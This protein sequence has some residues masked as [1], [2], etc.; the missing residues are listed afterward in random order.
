MTKLESNIFNC[1]LI[2]EGGGMRAS[3][4][5]AVLN[6][7]LAEGVHFNHVYGVSAG[8]SN[9]VN[10]IS[11]DA[12]RAFESFTTFVEDPEFGNTRTF[13]QRKGAFN[14]QHIYQEAGE[15]DGWLPFDFETFAANPAQCTICAF[16]RDT[17]N[18]R[19]FT[20]ADMNTLYN[21]MTCVRASSTLPIAMPPLTL[22][23][24]VLYD[25]GLG[26]G[27]G[28]MLPQA[29]ADGFSKFFIVRTRPKGFR[30]PEEVSPALL[31]YYWRYPAMQEAL[32]MWG[33]GYN[34]M[35]DLLEE[36]EAQGRAYVV[37]AED[38][39]CENSTKDLGLLVDNYLAGAAQ[40]ERDWPKWKEFLGL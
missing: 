22:G 3:Y 26:E 17:G 38:Q 14:A 30:K 4:S 31:R 40:A 23:G 21:L 34:S 29:V 10:Y 12:N 39:M 28:L 1:A 33:P 25:G 2:F 5:S 16:E 32:R 8:S 27:H 13:L 35:C 15:A 9:T 19:L 24:Q 20:K 18:T 37:Y 11:R 36:L 6:K 7:L